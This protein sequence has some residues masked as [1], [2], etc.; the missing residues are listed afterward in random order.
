MGSS[1]TASD[2]LRKARKS[3]SAE[4][5]ASN[6]DKIQP[7][8]P[9]GEPRAAHKSTQSYLHAR[10]CQRMKGDSTSSW[11]P[12]HMEELLV[13]SLTW[14]CWGTSLQVATL[15]SFILLLALFPFHHFLD[16]VATLLRSMFIRP[17]SC[18]ISS[19]IPPYLLFCC[20]LPL[21]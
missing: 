3:T 8:H 21:P 15:S 18:M 17:S 4:R 11:S 6:A 19:S 14:S 13:E 1:L 10:I 16:P 5:Q 7:A 20:F 2:R 9:R 12:S